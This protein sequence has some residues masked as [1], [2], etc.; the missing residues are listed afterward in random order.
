MRLI[1]FLIALLCIA[2]GV[3]VG[4]LNPQPVSLDFGFA[5]LHGT[6]GVSLL[7]ALLAGAIAGGMMLAASVVLPLRR[8]LRRERALRGLDTSPN[9]GDA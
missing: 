6:L 7:M 2:L 9:D 3:V 1:R 4:A 8:Q 5:T